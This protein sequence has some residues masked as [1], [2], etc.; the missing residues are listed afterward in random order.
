[1]GGLYLEEEVF[2]RK[3]VKIEFRRDFEDIALEDSH[4]T[5]FSSQELFSRTV[6]FVRG[7]L[8]DIYQSRGKFGKSQEELIRDRNSLTRKRKL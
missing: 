6:D 2:L 4:L 8:V 5:M 3:A 1:M 7:W